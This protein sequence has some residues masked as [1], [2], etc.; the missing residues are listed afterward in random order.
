MGVVSKVSTSW[1]EFVF[2][3]KEIPIIPRC[4]YG[5]SRLVDGPNLEL[6]FCDK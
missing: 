6:S 1:F 4:F 2:D 3:P 5:I